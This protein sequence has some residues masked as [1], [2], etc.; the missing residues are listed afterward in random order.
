VAAILRAKPTWQRLGVG[1]TTF[2]THY[3]KR[4]G[5][6]EF[7]PNT[8][9]RRLRPVELSTKTSG[10]IEDEVD[11]LIE[12]LRKER[13]SGRTKQVERDQGRFVKAHDRASNKGI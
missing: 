10:F 8:N 5:G 13:D 11:V 2:Y 4:E 12:G 9:V 3:V 1:R 7:V 6:S